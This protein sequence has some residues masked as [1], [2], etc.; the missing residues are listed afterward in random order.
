MPYGRITS[1]AFNPSRYDAVMAVA[2]SIDFSEWPGL[3]L[4]TV[5]R[6]AEDRL[7]ATAEYG[8]QSGGGCEL[9]ER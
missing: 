5:S 3:K 2:K 8:G 9:G 1:V 7:V 4:L 6:H